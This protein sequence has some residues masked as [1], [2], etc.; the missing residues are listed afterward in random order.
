MKIDEYGNVGY[1]ERNLVD[2]LKRDLK[3]NVDGC[4]LINGE[5]YNKA[6]EIN[7]SDLVP[8]ALWENI[9]RTI[10]PSEFHT[11][12]SN[13]WT[14]PD[15]YKNFDVAKYLLDQCNNSDEELQRMG[16]ELLLFAEKDLLPFLCYL[17]YM[18][19]TLRKNNI[20]LGVG[21]GSSVASFAL[22]KLGVHKINSLMFDIDIRE[23]LKDK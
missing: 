14:V 19:D 2:I 22:Y 8:Y 9:D 3:A 15:E 1:T 5:L 11:R 4:F 7:F 21:R 17:K 23:F 18:V 6:I 10:S 16:E 13:I 20:V 12:L